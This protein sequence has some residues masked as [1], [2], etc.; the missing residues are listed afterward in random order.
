MVQDMIRIL[1]AQRIVSLNTLF[2]LADHLEAVAK[3]E[4]LNTTLVNKLA[5]RITEIQ[6]P[7][8]SLSADEKNAHGLRLL[9]RAAHRRGAQTEPARR[10][11]EGRG[12]CRKS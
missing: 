4:K 12:R 1:E 11:R 6:L 7:R 8:A 3:G 5:S 9:D 2:E 10:H